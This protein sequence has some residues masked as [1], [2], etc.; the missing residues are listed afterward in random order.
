MSVTNVVNNPGN[1]LLLCLEY[2]FT[3]LRK[4]RC[5]FPVSNAKWLLSTGISITKWWTC[6]CQ[7]I[8][9]TIDPDSA[10]DFRKKKAPSLFAAL[11]VASASTWDT[12]R[13]LNSGP[14]DLRHAINRLT[15]ESVTCTPFWYTEAF[16][17]GPCRPT[18]LCML[19]LN[20]VGVYL[21]CS[22]GLKMCKQAFCSVCTNECICVCMCTHT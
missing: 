4:H 13:T 1:S 18:E 6:P 21:K 15:R 7:P 14:D 3:N 16:R 5:K 11:I 8:D 2:R 10:D 9:R 12:D 19:W 20:L 17:R 22:D